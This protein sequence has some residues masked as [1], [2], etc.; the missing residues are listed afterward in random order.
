M[1]TKKVV[2]NK[3]FMNKLADMIHNPKNKTF[4]RLCNGTLQN[5]PDPTNAKRPMHC[6]LGELYFAMTKRQPEEDGVGESDVVETAVELSTFVSAK[7]KAKDL[8][9][10]KLTQ[11]REKIRKLDVSKELKLSL[12]ETITEEIEELDD[13]E[14]DEESPEALKEQKFRDALDD[15]PNTNDDGVEEDAC[16]IGNYRARSKRVA[17]QLRKAAKFLPA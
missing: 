4:L 5:G 1:S 3:A 16:T 15:I 10:K 2:V 8:E 14:P 13:K 7:E 9:Y 11:A 12:I 6:G 17:S